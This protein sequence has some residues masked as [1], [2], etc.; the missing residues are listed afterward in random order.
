MGSSITRGNSAGLDFSFEGPSKRFLVEELGG[1]TIGMRM[2]Y[3]ASLQLK[4]WGV[5][6]YGNE[7]PQYDGAPLAIRDETLGPDQEWQ[8][9]TWGRDRGVSYQN[10]TGRP[11]QIAVA[12]SGVS[13]DPASFEVSSDGS[14]WEELIAPTV[15]T[16]YLCPTLPAGHFARWQGERDNHLVMWK[17]LRE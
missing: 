2:E 4:P 9:V 15:S 5:L 1:T 16:V 3:G 17:E 12:V 6:M 11:M 14:S 8:N 10:T 13:G 7:R